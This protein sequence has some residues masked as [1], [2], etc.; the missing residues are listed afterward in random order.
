MTHRWNEPVYLDHTTT[1]RSCKKCPLVKVSRH[2]PDNDPPH[3]FEWERDGE[4][5]QSTKTP[6]CEESTMAPKKKDDAETEIRFGEL[7]ADNFKKLK[8]VSIKPDGGLFEVAGMNEAG[9]S[10]VLDAFMAAIGGPK[11][12]PPEP[13]RRGE[14]ESLLQ[15]DLGAL[16]VVR[17]IWN[18]D[19]G[20]VGQEVVVQ[21]ANG[22]RPTKPQTVLDEL[23][24][25]HIADDPV[26]FARLEPK[27]RLDLLKKLV[28]GVDFDELA[29]ERQDLFEERTQVGR[30]RDRAL[31][32]V[33]SIKLP[34]GAPT[35]P[36][37]VSELLEKV[38]LATEAN[39]EVDRRAAAREQAADRAGE[40]RDEADKLLAQ[41]AAKNR[42]ADQLEAKLRGAEALPAK[43]DVSAIQAKVLDAAATNEQA[44][45]AQDRARKAAEHKA[46]FDEYQDLGRK[47]DEIDDRKKAAIAGAK[48]P[49]E[50]LGF[51]DDDITLDGLPFEQASAARRIRVATALLMALKPDI[52]VLL[53]REGSLLD[54]GMRE[55][56][57]V[58]AVRNKFVVL[59]ETVGDGDGTG[60]VIRDGEVA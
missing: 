3:W 8:A 19:G 13:V 56:L 53:V 33:E 21:W 30:D 47:I 40:L 22:K 60:V 41:A 29:Q 43:I 17:R 46:L 23:R 55:A 27:K 11:Y 26:A 44:R 39:A 38:K 9:K 35:E 18:R 32:A 14:Q 48:L 42:E 37:D 51:G 50:G 45:L 1:L 15:V 36:V 59:F 6:A 20:G 25:S 31:G 49:V 5:F 57:H 58:E 34:A 2:E 16:V 28:P 54:D 52:K 12:F 10:S 4:R 24:G 7:R